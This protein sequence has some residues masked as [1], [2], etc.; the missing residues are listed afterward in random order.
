[1]NKCNRGCL[2][3]RNLEIKIARHCCILAFHVTVYDSKFGDSETKAP[4][5]SDQCNKESDKMTCELNENDSY[6]CN[7]DF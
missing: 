7:V 2:Q 4:F 6:C 1:M 5:C 3:V